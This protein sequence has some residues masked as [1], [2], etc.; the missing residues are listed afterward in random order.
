MPANP[1]RMALLTVLTGLGLVGSVVVACDGDTTP[2]PAPDHELL[3]QVQDDDYRGWARPAGYDARKPSNSTHGGAVE[4]FTNAVVAEALANKDGLGLTAW[5]ENATIVIEG[6]A[7]EMVGEF[8]Q[9]A[10]MQ[11]Q[12]GTWYWEQ[13]QADD[14]ERPRFRGRPDICLGC[15]IGGQDFVRSFGLPKPVE[16]K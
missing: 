1:P 10:V 8:G 9:I 12:H 16:E 3:T 7:D 15:H 14:L 6:Y 11:K 5:P 13:Y 2:A 4:V